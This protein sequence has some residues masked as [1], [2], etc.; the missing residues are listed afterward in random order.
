MVYFRLLAGFTSFISKRCLSHL[1]WIGPDGIRAFSGMRRPVSSAPDHPE[2]TR[3]HDG[4]EAEPDEGRQAQG[5]APLERPWRRL[6]QTEAPAAAPHPVEE[7]ES[8]C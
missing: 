4:G 3:D 1:S 5:E 2:E 6:A 7:M 8:D